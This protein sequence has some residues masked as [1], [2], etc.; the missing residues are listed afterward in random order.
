MNAQRR[1]V[2]LIGKIPLQAI[3]II[4][5]VVQILLI[6]G[7]IGYISFRNSQQAVDSLVAEL[8]DET[9]QRIEERLNQ[10]LATPHLLNKLQA[11]ALA[12]GQLSLED[13]AQLTPYFWQNLR[14]FE[15]LNATF[16][17]TAEGVMVGARRL[18]GGLEVMLS[19]PATGQNLRYYTPDTAGMPATL[20]S[21]AGPYDPRQRLWYVEASELE[22]AQ[23]SDIYVDFQTRM[24][25]ITAGQPVYDAE[26][27][28]L[29]VLGS[30]FQFEQVNAFM[31]SLEIGENGLSFIIERDG[32]LVTSSTPAPI[33]MQGDGGDPVRLLGTESSDTVIRETSQFL[34]E[35]FNG[36]EDI[37]AS[38]N[39][40][41]P[42]D[43]QEH[44]V[45]VTPISDAF[46][47]DWLVVV[48]IPVSDFTAQIE[49]SRRTTL[50]AIFVSLL[51]AI[52]IGIVT[53]N[54]V[55]RPLR[56]LRDAALAFSEGDLGERITHIE[57]EDELGLLANTFNQMADELQ[58]S[59]AVLQQSQARYESMFDYVPIMLLEADYS[60]CRQL[61]TR[62]QEDEQV[63][64]WGAYFHGN[65]A[66]LPDCIKGIKILA[67]NQTVLETFELDL[68]KPVPHMTLQEVGMARTYKVI[69]RNIE[70]FMA[71]ETQFEAEITVQ[72]THG[73]ERHLFVRLAIVPG[74]EETWGRVLISAEDITQRIQMDAALRQSEQRLKRAQKMAQLGDWEY[75]LQTGL[76]S[77]SDELYRLYE[78]S[79]EEGVPTL[80]EALQYAH[81]E[82]YGWLS[83]VVK[84]AS[85]T[86]QPSVNNYRVLLPSGRIAHHVNTIYP[87][88][89]EH[90]RVYKLTGTLQ[91]ITDR[92]LL[93]K[94]VQSQERLAAVGQLAAGIAH[95]F[96]NILSSIAL[97]SDLLLRNIA[98]LSPKNEKRLKIITNQAGRASQLI[99]QILD[100]SR[101]SPL[102]RTRMNVLPALQELIDLLQRTLP[103]NITLEFHHDDNSYVAEIDA[104]RFQQIFMNLAVNARD[105]MSDGGSLIFTVTPL[106][107][108]DTA[109]P[110]VADMRPGEWIKIEVTDTGT[111]IPADLLPRIFEPFFTTK[112]TGKGTGLGLAQVYGVVLQFAGEITVKSTVGQGTTFTIYLPRLFDAPTPPLAGLAEVPTEGEG[113]TILVVEDDASAREAVVSALESL[114]YR[115]VVAKHGREALNIIEAAAKEKPH[116]DIILSDMLMPEMS[117]LE[118]VR[119]LRQNGYTIPVVMLSGY[120][121]E[122]DLDTMNELQVTGWLNKPP[123]LKQLAQLIQQGLAQTTKYQS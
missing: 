52:F 2:H 79:C 47:L 38:H 39:L 68:A 111:G 97:Y 42:I 87:M 117:G 92:V 43:G 22:L 7:I 95:D 94:R 25:V 16:L 14:L 21:D 64:D 37:L 18:E 73:R 53:T 101:Q 11:Q 34:Q 60:D 96:N 17:G 115:L 69:Q 84:Q 75:D 13:P 105:V 122:D 26:G 49:A 70:M 54:W 85:M 110:P 24:S 10:Y 45:R 86:G 67:V 103:E 76:I 5:F 107:L 12:S 1:L 89:D 90:G 88:R 61:L 99:Q 109:T 3:F 33:T 28:L 4:P 8:Q 40:L 44:Y 83:E 41:I 102:Q 51:G 66:K 81:P 77:W 58:T 65:P 62:W 31:Q 72:D 36:L 46:G 6:V 30:A 93:E 121:L 50:G 59:F 78:R 35:H 27:Q 55:T 57:R 29:G 19:S 9:S 98:N 48:G 114:N 23:W 100:F 80:E 120:L 106:T 123:N 15:E 56:Q 71:G 113:E 91:D 112:E 82:E 20:N 108:S 63:T 104:T 32:I 74:H 118:F 119:Y 116:I